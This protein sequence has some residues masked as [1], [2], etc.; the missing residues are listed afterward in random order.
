MSNIKVTEYSGYKLF[1]TTALH[2]VE[3]P[4][5]HEKFPKHIEIGL[6]LS[7]G[8]GSNE[9]AWA[10]E[11]LTKCVKF[12]HDGGWITFG[13]TITVNTESDLI[14]DFMFLEPKENHLTKEWAS[15]SNTPLAIMI[16]LQPGELDTLKISGF[17]KFLKAFAKG[18]NT[19]LVNFNRKTIK[20]K[21][22]LGIF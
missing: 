9:E 11:V 15:I 17:K 22:F 1:H 2:E 21:R 20:P 12:I 16:P 10:T 8:A 7:S 6:L 19:S 18:G 4:V 14:R 5:T 3:M 13:H